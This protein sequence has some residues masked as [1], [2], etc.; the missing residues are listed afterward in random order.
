M[1]ILQRRQDTV[2]VLV[3]NDHD[4]TRTLEVVNHNGEVLLKTNM[5][6]NSTMNVSVPYNC[7]LT[8]TD[9]INT[10]KLLVG[11]NDIENLR[12]GATRRVSNIRLG[13]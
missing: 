12:K 7:H 10:D 13:I 4:R 8:L 3:E 11:S 9:G 6:G 2:L 5:L 1:K